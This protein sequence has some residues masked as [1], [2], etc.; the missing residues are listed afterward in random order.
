M[1]S[2]ISRKYGHDDQVMLSARIVIDGKDSAVALGISLDSLR[3][4][5][6]NQTLKAA[7]AAYKR[8]TAIFIEDSLSSQLWQLLKSLMVEDKAGTL[9]LKSAQIVIA[10]VLHREEIELIEKRKAEQLAL[11]EAT[12]RL[13]KPT[14]SQFISQYI[15]ECEDGTRLKRRSTKKISPATVK[16]Y[17]TF[18]NIL[19]EYQRSRKVVIDWDDVTLDLY[20][21][22]KNYYIERG[23]SP[24]TIARYM[25]TFKIMLN[26]AKELHLTANDD[27]QSSRFSV[28]WEDVDNIYI[29]TE[30]IKEMYSLD[31]M[32]LIK[33]QK[34]IKKI[35]GVDQNE[36]D[37][38]SEFIKTESHRR[39]LD[40]ARDVFVA[41]CMLGQRVSDYSRVRDEMIESIR[42]R[43]FVHLT[44][45]KTGKEVYIPVMSYLRDILH[46]YHGTLPHIKDSKLNA[47]I[48]LV[49]LLLG[50]TEPA[51][52]NEQK[53]V[54]SYRSNKKF[55]ECITTHTAR[56][57]FA[58]NAY[59]AGV[60]LSAIM[61]ITGHSTELM[62]RKY[63]KL[64][65]KEKAVL[66]AAEFDKVAL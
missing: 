49:G 20:F 2:I 16:G 14:L 8:G 11:A 38:L 55:Y 59:K 24:N 32:S 64:D 57:S 36:T 27:F 3:W 1:V 4:Q 5:L 50:W 40:S 34:R 65:G 15:T 18:R 30:R 43:D 63:L 10:N 35:K 23:F 66:A 60:P 33:L 9:T 53:G 62:L 58:T 56:R 21:N 42:N 13:A 47:R 6:I 48:K 61:A 17:K 26:A 19:E 12:A 45:Q 29:T 44:Q 54:M 37:K 31:L 7:K 25:R 41:G 46:K 39:M 28:D 52:I 22:L 51:G